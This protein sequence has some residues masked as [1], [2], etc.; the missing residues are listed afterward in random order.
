MLA[1][2]KNI[3]FDELTSAVPSCTPHPS[4]GYST[5]GSLRKIISRVHPGTPKYSLAY[6]IPEKAS[7]KCRFI[8]IRFL[9]MSH[10]ASISETSKTVPYLL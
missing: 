6:T 3:K 10:C 7:L 5:T 8:T 2:S 1:L 9:S 4:S